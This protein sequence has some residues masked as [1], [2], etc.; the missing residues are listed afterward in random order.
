MPWPTA[1]AEPAAGT[2]TMPAASTVV[3]S[4]RAM[5]LFMGDHFRYGDGEFRPSPATLGAPTGRR[6]PVRPPGPPGRV[7]AAA[8]RAPPG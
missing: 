6:A 1:K 5:R 3:A 2:A 4:V 7:E 8:V